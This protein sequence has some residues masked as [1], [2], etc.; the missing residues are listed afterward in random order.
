MTIFHS[1]PIRRFV[2][3]V[4]R[5]VVVAVSDVLFS[6]LF[7]RFS[8]DPTALITYRSE[9]L[10]YV[11]TGHLVMLGMVIPI[12]ACNQRNHSI[13]PV[14]ILLPLFPCRMA[15]FLLCIALDWDFMVEYH[16]V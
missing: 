1:T 10:F 2:A 5:C 12:Y 13:P 8:I 16:G 4:P 9:R 15:S 11:I 6:V 3:A 14:R 7:M